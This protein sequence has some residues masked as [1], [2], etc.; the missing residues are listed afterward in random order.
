[1]NIIFNTICYLTMFILLSWD[2]I[3]YIMKKEGNNSTIYF[4]YIKH[5]ICEIHHSHCCGCKLNLTKENIKVNTDNYINI[6]NFCSKFTLKF[7]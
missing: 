2:K 7:F 6:Y 4:I 5:D 1:M 3:Y